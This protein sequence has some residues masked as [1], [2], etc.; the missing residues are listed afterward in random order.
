MVA[1]TFH[2]H[3]E[4]QSILEVLFILPFLFLFVGLLYKMNMA[5]QMAINNSQFAR[6][7]VYVLTGNSSEYPRLGFTKF[8]P[9]HFGNADQDRM[10]LGVADVE[11]L[12]ESNS[13]NGMSPIPQVQKIARL[14]STEKGSSER[15]EVKK[16]TEVRVRNTMGICTQLN[17]VGSKT[18]MNEDSI[19]S[20]GS[21]RWP[22]GME[23]CQ[24]GGMGG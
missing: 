23:V 22:F 2:T 24:Y 20:L 6:A 18:P 15:G 7:Q 12:S 16:R 9:I 17:S 1:K 11:A 13:P 10:V 5:A 4:G 8:S 21:K 19:P 3:E 14:S